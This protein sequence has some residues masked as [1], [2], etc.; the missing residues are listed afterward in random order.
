MSKKSCTV[1]GCERPYNCKGYCE[2]HY[3]RSRGGKTPVHAPVTYGTGHID[4]KGYRKIG[5][6][7]EHRLVMERV[8]GR[9]LERYEIVHH[10]NGIRHDNRPENLEIWINTHPEGARVEDK[11]AYAVW[12]LQ[13]YAPE[14]LSTQEEQ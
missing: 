10:K 7:R 8:L 3:H 9:K 14:Q 2:L 12:I 1:E 11:I 5:T 13:R 4:P 6:K